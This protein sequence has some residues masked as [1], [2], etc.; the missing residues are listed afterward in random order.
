MLNPGLYICFR[1]TKIRRWSLLTIS[2]GKC[3]IWD[4]LV[5]RSEYNIKCIRSD[6][7]A[8]WTISWEVSVTR[9]DRPNWITSPSIFKKAMIFSSCNQENITPANPPTGRQYIT[10]KGNYRRGTEPI[11]DHLVNQLKNKTRNW[12]LILAVVGKPKLQLF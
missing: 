2:S 11:W 6:I 5:L 9:I 12:L 8:N 3:K 7:S 4:H 1:P 10:L